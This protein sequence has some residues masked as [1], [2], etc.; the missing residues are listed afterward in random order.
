M[1]PPLMGS[2]LK[3]F[4]IALEEEACISLAHSLLWISHYIREYLFLYI[5]LNCL[6]P[7]GCYRIYVYCTN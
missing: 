5:N 7:T 6:L 3:Y 2:F 1:L 4:Y